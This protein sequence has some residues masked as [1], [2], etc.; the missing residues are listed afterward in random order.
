MSNLEIYK[1]ER[2]WGFFRRFTNNSLSTVKILSLKPNEALSLQS[3]KDREEFWR[4]IAGSG[5]IEIN[6]KKEVA[7]VGDEYF[8]K[9]GEKHRLCAGSNGLE[10]LEISL[11]HFSEDDVVRYSDNYGRK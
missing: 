8:I 3:H 1:E 9:A 11:G 6:D 2:P 5:D 7:S 4:V 10:V